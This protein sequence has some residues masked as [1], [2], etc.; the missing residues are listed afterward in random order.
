MD[1]I[2]WERL[3]NGVK[4]Y[5]SLKGFCERSLPFNFT[6]SPLVVSCSSLLDHGSRAANKA[7]GLTPVSQLERV[8]S[9]VLK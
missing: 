7:L 3:H 6:L 5:L 8:T 4:F 2:E 9:V 1:D